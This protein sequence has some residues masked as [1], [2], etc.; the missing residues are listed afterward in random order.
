MAACAVQVCM[1][2]QQ[3]L[4]AVAGKLPRQQAFRTLVDALHKEQQDGMGEAPIVQVHPAEL[5]DTTTF[6][7]IFWAE[8]ASILKADLLC[9]LLPVDCWCT[10]KHCT[11]SGISSDACLCMVDAGAAAVLCCAGEELGKAE[12]DAALQGPLM[13]ALLKAF[14]HSCA[15]VRKSVG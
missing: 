8:R 14:Q 9:A 11:L 13:L 15:D 12:A 2:A 1:L 10:G 3:A 4:E 5:S 7:G 6:T